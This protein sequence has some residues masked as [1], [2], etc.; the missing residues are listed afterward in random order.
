MKI[1]ISIPITGH[2]LATQRTKAAEVAEKIKA[3]GHEPVNPFDT[4]APPEGLSE[5]Q[6]YA[7]YMLKDIRQLFHCDAI[8]MCEGWENSYGCK[9]ELEVAVH[10]GCSVYEDIGKINH[11]D[12]YKDARVLYSMQEHGFDIV[13]FP[14][15]KNYHTVK[16]EDI[17][18]EGKIVGNGMMTDCDLFKRECR[19]NFIGEFTESKNPI[20]LGFVSEEHGVMMLLPKAEVSISGSKMSVK[21]HE[22]KRRKKLTGYMIVPITP[23]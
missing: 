17:L 19:V 14:K 16:L 3:L 18:T 2:D 8:F 23:N 7:Y 20:P 6:K 10:L 9:I 13:V 5:T 11:I 15:V 12:K 22:I 4:S 1:Y 21:W